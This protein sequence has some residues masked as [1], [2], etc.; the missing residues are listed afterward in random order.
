MTDLLTDSNQIL[1][2]D[3]YEEPLLAL[4]HMISDN[5]PLSKIFIELVPEQFVQRMLVRP[6]QLIDWLA[7]AGGES[8]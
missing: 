3:N 1:S 8:R 5:E 4:F 2:S 7:R 6:Y